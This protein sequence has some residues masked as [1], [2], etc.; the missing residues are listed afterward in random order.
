[1][2]QYSAVES[3]VLLNQIMCI[4]QPTSRITN[5]WHHLLLETAVFYFCVSSKCNSTFVK[6]GNTCEVLHV[7]EHQMTLHIRQLSFKIVNSQENTFT[8]LFSFVCNFIWVN[9][10]HACACA[11]ARVCVC[12]CVWSLQGISKTSLSYK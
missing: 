10:V 5:L 6:H 8:E 2:Q 9:S 1:M 11:R 7:T 12:V 3:L 4:F